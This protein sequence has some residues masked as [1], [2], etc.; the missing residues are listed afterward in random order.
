MSLRDALVTVL[1]EMDFEHD[2]L[3]TPRIVAV[4]DRVS[5]TVGLGIVR[6]DGLEVKV[7]E[8]AAGQFVYVSTY[9]HASASRGFGGHDLEV[10]NSSAASSYIFDQGLFAKLTHPIASVAAFETPDGY[11]SAEFPS[12]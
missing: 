3:R 7:S 8:L 2:T 5:R 11:E 6:D 12:Q 1:H 4:S 9:E 10:A